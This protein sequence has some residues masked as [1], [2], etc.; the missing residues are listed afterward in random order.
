MA[1]EEARPDLTIPAGLQMISELQGEACM[2][3]DHR[4][5]HYERNDLIFCPVCAEN[6]FGK[7]VVAAVRARD[8]DK[9]S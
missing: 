5:A 2:I 1:D 6:E 8:E 3:C 9:R 4:M 7:E